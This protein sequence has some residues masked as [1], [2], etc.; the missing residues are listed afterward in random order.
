MQRSLNA[1]SRRHRDEV[2]FRIIL[3]STYPFFLA[4]ALVQWL[5]PQGRSPLP[6]QRRSIFAEAKGMAT[7]AIPFAFMG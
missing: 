3:V 7:S 5:I 1:P 2:L 6:R 4:A